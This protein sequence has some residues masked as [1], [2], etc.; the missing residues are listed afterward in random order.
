MDALRRIV[1]VLGTSAR[2]APS[3]AGISGAQLFLLRLIGAAPGI[4]M[5]KLAART[6]AGQSTISEVVTRLVDQRL[7]AR[8]R[9]KDDA[10]RVVLTLTRRGSEIIADIPPTAQERLVEGLATMT[11]VQQTRLAHALEDWLERAGFHDV[12]PTMFFEDGG[13]RTSGRSPMARGGRE[14]D[15]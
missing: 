7:V 13:A 15:E 6:L 2:S 8:A 9:G 10:R 14:S 1:R 3:A 12:P 5:G 11:P 4:S